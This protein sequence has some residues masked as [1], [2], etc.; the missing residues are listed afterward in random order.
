MHG[1]F[2]F[3][4]CIDLEAEVVG[5][6]YGL[7]FLILG[8][9]PP[10]SKMTPNVGTSLIGSRV[11]RDAYQVQCLLGERAPFKYKAS[12]LNRTISHLTILLRKL[13]SSP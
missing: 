10:E 2:Y 13:S 1:H 9:V 4:R 6:C 7:E 11:C 3:R 5:F 8:C 12:A